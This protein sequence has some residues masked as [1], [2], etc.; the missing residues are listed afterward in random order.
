MNEKELPRPKV[1][2]E[3]FWQRGQQGSGRWSLGRSKEFG[4]QSV[5]GECG[6]GLTRGVEERPPGADHPGLWTKESELGF[7]LR[8]AGLLE[9]YKRSGTGNSTCFFKAA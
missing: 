1:G 9:D 3:C 8:L 4:Q 6:A 5:A 2:E 7:T